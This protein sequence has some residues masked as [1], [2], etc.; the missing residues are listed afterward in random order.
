MQGMLRPGGSPVDSIY[1]NAMLK[2]GAQI[3]IRQTREAIDTF[4]G[5]Y[6]RADQLPDAFAENFDIRFPEEM[7]VVT[8]AWLRSICRAGEG[9]ALWDSN[10][11]GEARD[12]IAEGSELS[13][14][15]H[16]DKDARM[17]SRAFS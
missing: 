8:V 2:G 6:Q 3:M 11:P 7:W 9:L 1:V 17:M 16:L 13:I 15:P 14:N 10:R 4:R 5:G 12:R